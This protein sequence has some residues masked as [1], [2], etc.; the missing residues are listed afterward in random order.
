MG[1]SKAYDSPKWPGVNLAVG[2]AVSSGIDDQELANAVSIFADA[3]KT[4][5]SS[6]RIGIGSYGGIGTGSSGFGRRPSTGGRGGGS[7]GANRARSASSGARLANFISTAGQSGLSEAL[8]QFNIYEF[9]DQP[10]EDFLDSLAD[11]LSG[12]GGLLDDDALNRAMADTID[13]LAVDTQSVEEFD[14]LLTSG[15]IDLEETLQVYYANVLYRNFEQKEYSFVREKIER[16]E[17]NAFFSRAHNV[18]R[19]IV[20]EELFQDRELSSINWNSDEGVRIAD[21]INQD[22][23]EILIP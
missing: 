20:R 5:I 14:T 11:W 12:D 18:I 16:E 6:G 23:L 21:Q 15:L 2:D 3:Y 4:H 17:T 19:A 8:R 9:I 22:V 7:G 13:E 10:L 1:T